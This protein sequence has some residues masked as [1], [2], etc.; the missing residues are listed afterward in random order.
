VTGPLAQRRQRP[1]R[2]ITP[3]PNTSTTTMIST[4]N[5]VDMAA[6][7]VD[8]GIVQADATAAHPSKQLGHGQTDRTEGT[9]GSDGLD[10]TVGTVVAPP[11][12]ATVELL[13]AAIRH[14][15]SAVRVP[16]PLGLGLD[17]V[18]WGDQLDIHPITAG[19][20]AQTSEASDTR[21]A[22]YL[23]KY[24]TKA[25]EALAGTTLDQPIKTAVALARLELPDH[26]R[27]LAQACWQLGARPELRPLHLHAWAHQLGYGG[28]CT[29]KS[30][31]YSV[32]LGALRHARHEHA[33]RAAFAGEPTDAWG[34][35]E[36]HC[37][38]ETVSSWT[39]QGRGYTSSG[40]AWLARSM[41]DNAREQRRIAREE[42]TAVA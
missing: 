34:R 5:H 29:T 28:H 38:D 16:S 17:P 15:T 3:N 19:V 8:P 22:G 10:G 21:V 35:P 40:D 2:R 39:Y 42:V 4:H 12:W 27:R 20:L 9:D 18:G 32:T 11:A 14:A 36:H 33:R 13:T 6:S 23:A 37:A 7:L 26:I 25:T 31:R 30:R 1:R 24:A 41:L